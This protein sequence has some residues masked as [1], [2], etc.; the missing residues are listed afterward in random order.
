ML[1]NEIYSDTK[2]DK[3]VSY[4]FGGIFQAI[5][6]YLAF[7]HITRPDMQKAFD[8]QNIKKKKKIHNG[9]VM[10]SLFQLG[11]RI[12]IQIIALHNCRKNTNAI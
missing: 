10:H 4:F 8:N 11:H 5:P 7:Y 12:R 3:I 6:F 2:S 9:S 1:C